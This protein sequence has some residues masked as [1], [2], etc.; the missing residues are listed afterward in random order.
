VD[1]KKRLTNGLQWG[2]AYT[3]STTENNSFNFVSGVAVPT[4]PDLSFGPDT[5]D[6]RHR[7]EAHAEINLPFGVQF[8]VIADYRSEAP[9]DIIASGR[10]LNGD[11]ISG[12]CGQRNPVHCAYRRSGVSGL[13]LLA[14]FRARNVNRGR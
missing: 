1:V 5:E 3:L 7:V 6:R 2:V 10:D 13:P 14:K 11:G 12:D 4:H 9:L 8:G